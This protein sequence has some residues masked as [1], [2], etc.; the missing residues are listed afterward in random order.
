MNVVFDAHSDLPTYV[1]YSRISGKTKVLEENFEKFFGGHIGARVMAIWTV[2]EKR[3]TALR[4]GLE[5][6]NQL[7]RDVAESK[8]FTIVT[9][10]KDMEKARKDGKVA[11]WLG[12]EGGEPLEDS[13]DLLEVF[14]RLGVRV[15]TLTW[16]L[17]NSIGDGVLER[18]NSGLTSF[19][20]EVLKKAEE[21]G[22]VVDV[23]HLNE[24]GFWDVIENAT[25]PIIASH[26]NAYALC[27]DPRNLK[28]EQIKA[29]AEKDGVIGVNVIPRFVDK[30]KPTLD[31]M[32]DHIEYIMNLAGYQ[33]VGLGFDFVYYLPEGE[34]KILEGL[35]NETKIP[36]LLEKLKETFSEKEVKAI[37]FENF[38]RVFE[39]V[40]G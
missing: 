39:K 13:L 32:I 14:Y 38:K 31:R 36:A 7:Y 10:V 15:L 12:L 4:Y 20:I 27:D 17:R 33:H 16:N 34:K 23:S 11:L 1:Y 19:G 24:A 26:S 3:P 8:R 21:F 30:K 35:E 37:T 2:E 28:D 25:A 22:I 40:V 29:I 18:T 6:L 9:S 5:A